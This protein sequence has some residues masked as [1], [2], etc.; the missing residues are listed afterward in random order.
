MLL[1][2]L[3]HNQTCSNITAILYIAVT[4]G[5]TELI[6]VRSCEYLRGSVVDP[7]TRPNHNLPIRGFFF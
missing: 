5:K 1:C 3:P 2:I 4:R 7:Q 6:R